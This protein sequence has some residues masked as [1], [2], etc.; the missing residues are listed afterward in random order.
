MS[1]WFPQYWKFQ[2][3][4]KMITKQVDNIIIFT[5]TGRGPYGLAVIFITSLM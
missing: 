4:N 2:T 1:F 3:E 5:N